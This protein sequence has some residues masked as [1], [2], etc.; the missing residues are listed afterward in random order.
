MKNVIACING[1]SPTLSTCKAS[2][3]VAKTIDAPLI[4]FNAIDKTTRP[5]PSELSGQI[6]LGSQ[7]ELLAEL[8]ELDEARSKIML[9]HSNKLL[10]D[11]TAWASNEG[12]VNVSKLQRHGSLLDNLLDLEDELRVLVIAKSEQENENVSAIGSQLESVIRSIKAHILV[13]SNKFQRPDSYLIAFD[14]SPI[15]E[16]LIAK[17]ISTPLLK[18]L[19]CHLVMVDDSGKKSAAFEQA[20]SEL[21]RVGINVQEAILEG[22][23]EQALLDYQQQHQIGMMVMGA[24]GHTK[25]RQFFVGSNTTQVLANSRVP[26]LLIR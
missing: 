22:P 3:W 12:V 9:R 1:I 25:L 6:G 10:E 11:A 21:Q 5:V 8:A 2:A 14:G 18:G 17:A 20:L 15:S 24:Y 19:D 13:V 4:L 7:E 26:L 16:K 23:I